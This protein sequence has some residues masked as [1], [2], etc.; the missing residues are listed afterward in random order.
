MAAARGLSG[1][2]RDRLPPWPERA[3]SRW[4]VRAASV[5][6]VAGGPRFVR[7]PWSWHGRKGPERA[8][9]LGASGGGMRFVQPCRKCRIAG[10]HRGVGREHDGRLWGPR[11]VRASSV[12]GRPVWGWVSC[13]CRC[14]ASVVIG[15]KQGN[16]SITRLIRHRPRPPGIRGHRRL[17]G[18]HTGRSGQ[19]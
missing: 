14:H 8:A 12:A 2:R 9:R 3:T 6:E 1:L 16:G 4:A 19:R 15:G 13:C 10:T 5:G 7:A 17:S 11:F 18:F